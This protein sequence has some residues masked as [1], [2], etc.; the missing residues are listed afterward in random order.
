MGH[1]QEAARDSC[2]IPISDCAL[3]QMTGKVQVLMYD[4]VTFLL[5]D[6][7][8]VLRIGD[9]RSILFNA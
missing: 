4:G 6:D 9:Y 1:H 8:L 3:I 5:A 7:M 2:P